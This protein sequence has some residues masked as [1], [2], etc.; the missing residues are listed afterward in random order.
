ML[1]DVRAPKR[2]PTKVLLV[3]FPA[4]ALS[5]GAFSDKKTFG[6]ASS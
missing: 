5:G 3:R 6:Q 1:V 4:R 2:V